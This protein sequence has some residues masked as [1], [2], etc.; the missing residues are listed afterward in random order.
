[1]NLKRYHIRVARV[2]REKALEEM[3]LI[4]LSQ[5]FNSF[6]SVGGLEFLE[7]KGLEAYRRTARAY[8]NKI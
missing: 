5:M 8:Y 4:C 2:L 7:K 1:M 6:V 3:S